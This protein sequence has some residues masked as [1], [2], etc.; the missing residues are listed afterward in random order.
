MFLPDPVV[1]IPN[2]ILVLRELHV[3]SGLGV[4]LTKC[5]ALRINIQRI[6][7][8]SIKESFGFSI[9]EGALQYLGVRL[10]PSLQALYNTNYSLFSEG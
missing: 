1:S 2:L 6:V 9:S 8:D 3:I 10:A 4:S 5:S 7:I